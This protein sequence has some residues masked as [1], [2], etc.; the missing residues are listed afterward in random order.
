MYIIVQRAP[1]SFLCIRFK[2]SI[3]IDRF[4][5]WMGL[6]LLITWLDLQLEI[7]FTKNDKHDS[8]Y[9]INLPKKNSLALIKIC[10]SNVNLSWC[11]KENEK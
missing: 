3:S 2:S 9:S 4:K 6:V 5:D 11:S 8:L 1:Y 7:F 10:P